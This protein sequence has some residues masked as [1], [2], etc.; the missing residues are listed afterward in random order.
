ML[1]CCVVET[2][3]TAQ[4]GILDHV[5]RQTQTQTQTQTWTMKERGAGAVAGTWKEEEKEKKRKREKEKKRE[6]KIGYRQR[7]GQQNSKRIT[8]ERIAQ[9]G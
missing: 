9:K 4:Q 7:R 6:R 1:P 8:K 5:Q 2:A 3:R